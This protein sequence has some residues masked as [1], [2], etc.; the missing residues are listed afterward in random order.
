MNNNILKVICKRVLS[1][2]VL[3]GGLFATFP[4]KRLFIKLWV[5]FSLLIKLVLVC[6]IA[7]NKGWF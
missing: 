1:R 2:L 4:Y 7:I 3:I 5:V 6:S